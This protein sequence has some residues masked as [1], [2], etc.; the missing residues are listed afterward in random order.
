MK[1]GKLKKYKHVF[2]GVTAV[3]A[4]VLALS[5][6]GYAVADAN[7]SALDDVFGTGTV[8]SDNKDAQAFP[9]GYD[10][11]D[12][13][14]A[15]AKEVAE[16]Q[17]EEG[18]VL[19][20]NDNGALPL[21]Q[22]GKVAL[23]GLAAYEPYIGS[24]GDLKA[25]NSDAVDLVGALGA[26]GI[27]VN[28]TV[29]NMYSAIINK[30]TVTEENPWTHQPQE[31]TEY[32]NIYTGTPGNFKDFKINEVPASKLVELSKDSAAYGDW[33]SSIT[34]SETVGICV[35]ARPG[36]ESNTYKPGSAV[37]FAGEKTG[38]DPLELSSDELSIVDAAKETCGKVVV[39]INS[40]NNMMLGA[41]AKG[42]AHEVDAIAYIGCTNDYQF[43]GIVKVLTGKANA[44][45][46]LAD[47][48]VYD[49]ASI[50]A[51]NNFGGAYYTD[52]TDVARS[53]DPRYPGVSIGNEGATSGGFGGGPATY[54]GGMYIVEAEGIYIGYK[55]FETRYFDMIMGQGN[56]AGTAGATQSANWDYGKEVLYTFGHGL[57]YYDYDQKVTG[58]TVNKL[59][60]TVA[61]VEVSNKSNNAGKFLAQLYVSRPYT[62]YDKT[63][64]V[65]KSAIDFLNSAKVDLGANETKTIEIK[66]PSKYLASYDEHGK[67]TYI[68]DDGDY[69][70]TAAAGS[71]EA[72]NNVL[73]KLGKGKANG[74]DEEGNAA[75]VFTWNNAQ[76]DDVTFSVSN[77]HNVENVAENADLN[78]WLPDT[79]TYLSRSD[80]QSTYPKNYGEEQITLANSA[81]KDEWFKELRNQQYDIKTTENQVVNPDGKDLGDKYKFKVENIGVEQ[82]KDVNDSFWDELVSQISVDQAIGGVI[83][84]GNRTDVY[85]NIDNQEVIQNEGVNGYTAAYSPADHPEDAPEGYT[86]KR[87]SYK[88]NISSQTLLGTSFN[89]QLAYDWGI[90]EGES[91]LWLRRYDVWGTGLT[92]RRTPYNGRNYEYISEDP[93]L[94]NRIG[95]GI[96]KGAKEKGTMCGP[97]HIGCNDQEY[98]RNGISAYM[99]EQKL[100]ETDLRGFEGGLNDAD[101]LAVMVAFNRIGATN[102][103]HHVGMLKNILREE[104]G[105]DGI[106]ST[107]MM[108][109]AYYFNPEAMIMATVTQVAD[110]LGNDNTISANEGVDSKWGY[111]SVDNCKRDA[112]LV[113][114][115]R[116][117]L[118][119]QF[120]AIA[121]SGVMNILTE[122]VTPWWETAIKVVIAVSASLL[123][124][125][126]AAYVTTEVLSMLPAKKEENENA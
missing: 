21:A 1:I 80:W 96:I 15:A 4:S 8:I 98:N 43:T 29:K 97:K 56:A 93:M 84:G 44:T 113:D 36:G 38:E 90:I 67:G 99:T 52:Y 86:P 106:I 124:I 101:G 92:L 30:R 68:L 65:E 55:Y 66:I 53:D 60:D 12:D 123:G 13:F 83:H 76:F 74:M 126:G 95:Y 63:N 73:A 125:A 120:Y 25:G 105:F 5:T 33:Q 91:G 58:V 41:I 49:N 75:A 78:Y 79:V 48:F 37:N 40:G 112:D 28:E 102:A 6:A 71:H 121:N 22:N 104:W 31:K 32:D 100:R 117:N 109:N 59:G 77:G 103:S 7:R 23:F 10:T 3:M 19:M 47:T 108:N 122:Y 51:V 54:N 114:Q 70:F 42:G 35:F 82:L 46:A 107:D 69:Y 26:A 27:S 87:D 16:R 88:F 111:I 61:Q 64:G 115:A 116:Q 24:A 34:K 17:G 110:F 57:S 94:T 39:L 62:E 89:E 20:K 81:K 45:G 14:A 118:K 18:T 50:P 119:Y 72:V 85:T 2:V 11:I 9:R